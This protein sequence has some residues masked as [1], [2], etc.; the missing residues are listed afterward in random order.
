MLEILTLFIKNFS[1]ELEPLCPSLLDLVMQQCEDE[2]DPRN[3]A[4]VFPLLAD[5]FTIY[6]TH[7]SKSHADRAADIL[8]AYYP[9]TYKAPT[10]DPFAVSEETIK[11]GLHRALFSHTKLAP[12][13]IPFF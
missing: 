9:I 10:G 7:L 6:K 4:L 2:K 11:A 13:V 3:L 8:T 12:E 1:V 5:V